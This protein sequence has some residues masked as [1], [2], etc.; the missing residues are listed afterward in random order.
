MNIQSV[1]AQRSL[2]IL[3]EGNERFR[4][5]RSKH[6]TYDSGQLVEIAQV[7]Q[8]IAAVVACADSRVTPEVVFDQPLGSIFCARVPGNVAADSAL[9]MV[10]IAVSE[11]KV[12]LVMVLGH[13]GCLAIGQVVHGLDQGVGGPLRSMISYAV[14]QAKTKS[15]DDLML[16]SVEANIAH[17]AEELPK[18]C[19]ALHRAVL[20]QETS[21]A[22]AIYEMESG[23]VRICG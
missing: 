23:F 5:G 22:G 1:S 8:P 21:V 16:A 14:F 11:F 10:D 6:W 3:M 2:D 20:N 9:W 19:A 17:T 12:P 15:P 4:A 7:Q 18:R 13:T